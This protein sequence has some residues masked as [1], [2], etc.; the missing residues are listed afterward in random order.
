MSSVVGY[1][2]IE[3]RSVESCMGM[4]DVDVVLKIIAPQGVVDKVGEW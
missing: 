3:K 4:L 1:V 2:D